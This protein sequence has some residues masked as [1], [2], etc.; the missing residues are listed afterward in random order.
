[1]SH[2]G[3]GRTDPGNQAAAARGKKRPGSKRGT[4]AH[5]RRGSNTSANTPAPSTRVNREQEKE[6]DAGAR[7]RAG[8]CGTLAAIKPEQPAAQ[9]RRGRARRR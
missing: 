7:R 2:Q 9:R 4:R 3:Q 6:H 8:E 1:V 5:I